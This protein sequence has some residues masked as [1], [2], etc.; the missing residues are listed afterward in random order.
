MAVLI[1][2][3]KSGSS[4]RG[5]MNPELDSGDLCGQAVLN[6]AQSKHCREFQCLLANARHLAG[7]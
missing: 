2:F 1:K 5:G 3:R 6:H 4:G 7:E